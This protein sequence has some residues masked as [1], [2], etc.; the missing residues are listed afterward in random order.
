MP[1]VSAKIPNCMPIWPYPT[2]PSTLPRASTEPTADL[3][4]SP[5]CALA[6]FSGIPRSNN[7]VS[8]ITNSATERVFEKGALKTGMP[9]FCAAFKST[10]LVPIQKQPIATNLL[11]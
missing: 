4:H 9:R 7:S 6:L 8:P 2:I 5:R 3:N 1:K 10:W 11:A